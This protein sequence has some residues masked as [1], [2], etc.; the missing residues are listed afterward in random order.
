[1]KLA[2]VTLYDDDARIYGEI[3]ADAKERYCHRWGYGFR[4]F[5]KS[6]PAKHPSWSKLAALARAMDDLPQVT[7]FFWSDADALIVDTSIPLESFIDDRY[8]LQLSNDDKGL[9]MG[10]FLIRNSPW[11]KR[12]LRSLPSYEW[13]GDRAWE[14]DAMK[15]YL[16]A[17]C[18]HPQAHIKYMGDAFNSYPQQLPGFILHCVCMTADD[19]FVMIREAV[20]RLGL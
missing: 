11:S 15:N 17:N 16:A 18:P 10:N 4:R 13:A 5:T 7:H 19:R 8:Q 20:D 6:D 1:M 12:L 14:Q 9:S 2:V 3:T